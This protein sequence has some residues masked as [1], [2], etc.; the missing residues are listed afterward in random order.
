MSIRAGDLKPGE[1]FGLRRL[2]DGRM[3]PATTGNPNKLETSG[4][5]LALVPVTNRGVNFLPPDEHMGMSVSNR[6]EDVGRHQIRYL[7]TMIAEAE[8]MI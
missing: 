7:K 4:R 8:H 3:V 6:A 5:H 1:S 2:P